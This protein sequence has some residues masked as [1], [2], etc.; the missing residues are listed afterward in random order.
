[1]Q[2]WFEYDDMT[3]AKIMEIFDN[4]GYNWDY[5]LESRRDSEE[6]EM[7]EHLEIEVAERAYPRLDS[8]KRLLNC[9]A[10]LLMPVI[11]IRILLNNC[12]KGPGP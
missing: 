4:Y 11:P 5:R 6:V 1:M 9:A 3:I 8:G 12:A 7:P 2:Q 10:P